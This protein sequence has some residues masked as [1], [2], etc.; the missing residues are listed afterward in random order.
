MPEPKPIVY[1]QP[2]QKLVRVQDERYVF[3]VRRNI[4]LAYIDP[5]HVQSILDMRGGCCGQSRTGIFREATEQEIR[6]WKG[7][8]D[9]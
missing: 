1:Y 2:I 3:V 7:E 8:A 4:S 5:E 6:L 9:R